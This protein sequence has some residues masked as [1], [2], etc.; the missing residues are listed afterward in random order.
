MKWEIKMTTIGASHSKTVNKKIVKGHGC[1]KC[2]KFLHHQC[3][4]CSV[5][6]HPARK[7]YQNSQGIQRGIYCED[8]PALCLDCAVHEGLTKINPNDIMGT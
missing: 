1:S 7:K 8:Y 4:R 3:A 6:I 2:G 5:L